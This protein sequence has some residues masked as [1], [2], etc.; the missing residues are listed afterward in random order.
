MDY[1]VSACCL[2]KFEFAYVCIFLLWSVVMFCIALS[3]RPFM[4]CD[5]EGYEIISVI[6]Y[7]QEK[8]GVVRCF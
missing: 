7:T 4:C 8:I 3:I 6:L 1:N 5:F 2:E